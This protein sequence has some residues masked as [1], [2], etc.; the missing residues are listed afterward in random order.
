MLMQFMYSK[1]VD[2]AKQ[3][4]P[5]SFKR[6][7]MP[8]IWTYM[9]SLCKIEDVSEFIK[10]NKGFDCFGLLISQ[11]HSYRAGVVAATIDAAT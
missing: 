4:V 3:N 6:E 7:T 2:I 11:N 10:V 9:F 1:H 8:I 5:F